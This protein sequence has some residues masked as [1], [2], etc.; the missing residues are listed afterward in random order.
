MAIKLYLSHQTES[1]LDKLQENLQGP[2]GDPFFS[3]PIILP[4]PNLAKW[5]KLR[6]ADKNGISANLGGQYLESLLW[7]L[8]SQMYGLKSELPAKMLRVND[9][10]QFVFACFSLEKL[11][12]NSVLK[13]YLLPYLS[14][15]TGSISPGKKVEFSY[16]LANLFL[17]YEYSRPGNPEAGQKGLLDAWPQRDF[18]QQI[19]Y[20]NQRR[21]QTASNEIWQ[22]EIYSLIFGE[23]QMLDAF[24][25]ASGYELLSMPRLEK[26]LE[27]WGGVRTLLAQI[28][29]F[30][31]LSQGL[32]LFGTSGLGLY[33]RQLI[34][35]L[36]GQLDFYVY[37]LNP[38]S[39]FW[40]DATPKALN[41][42]ERLSNQKKGWFSLKQKEEVPEELDNALPEENSL[43]V[44]WGK[45]GRES[46]HLWCQSNDYD[47]EYLLPEN[48][49]KKYSNIFKTLQRCIVLRK[50]G[51]SRK[52]FP[53]MEQDNS[54]QIW[55]CPDKIREVENLW[56]SIIWNLKTNPSLKL[57]DIAVFVPNL[58]NYRSQI[59]QVFLSKNPGE[60]GYLPFHYG[61]GSAAS[62]SY[63]NAVRQIIRLLRGQFSR[64]E[65]LEY[66]KN[67][68]VRQ[69]L[70]LGK[71]ELEV[72]KNWISELNIYR[73][74]DGEHRQRRG[75]LNQELHSF[76]HGIKR[77]QLGR[78]S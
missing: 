6:L 10:A 31:K 48:L 63:I 34:H 11:E 13:K 54:L 22:R 44:K 26:K 20:P 36:S 42:W 51:K 1:L 43:L 41:R 62:S 25:K 23:G 69:K 19:D 60:P 17:E 29:M 24:S 7:S 67:P 55:E 2:G 61:D 49:N 73:S 37:I 4:N 32:H 12:S 46:I 68:L 78:I 8:L 72:W 5:V 47:F 35:R 3:P 74:F 59:E 40:E 18:F 33:H 58:D 52:D 28:P 30:S 71:E 16:H 76:I 77:L 45:Y 57:N 27:S 56:N 9:L 70:S 66:F 38:C 14:D 64:P 53:P 21:R 75:E 50:A 65:I 39:Q 15:G